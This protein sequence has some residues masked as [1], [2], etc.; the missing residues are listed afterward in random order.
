LKSREDLITEFIDRTQP[1]DIPSI[2]SYLR[3]AIDFGYALCALDVAEQDKE[4]LNGRIR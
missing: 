4:K 3:Y 1:A 2:E